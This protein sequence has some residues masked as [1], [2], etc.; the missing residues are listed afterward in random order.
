MI[1]VVVFRKVKDLGIMKIP[2][3]IKHFIL[4]LKFCS[5]CHMRKIEITANRL[6]EKILFIIF[7]FFDS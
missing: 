6:I 7:K 1:S 2:L 5:C 4:T 3:P